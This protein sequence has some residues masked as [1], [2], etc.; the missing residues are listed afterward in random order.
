MRAGNSSSGSGA[1]TTTGGVV[2]LGDSLQTADVVSVGPLADT[3]VA[4]TVLDSDLLQVFSGTFSFCAA[5]STELAFTGTVVPETAGADVEEAAEFF[6]FFFLPA[7]EEGMSS[8]GGGFAEDGVAAGLL[9]AP[10]TVRREEISSMVGTE[11]NSCC[12]IPPPSSSSDREGGVAFS[13]S[14]TFFFL[15]EDDEFEEERS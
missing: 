14:P 5:V 15:R 2:A 4:V 8:L 6:C 12:V 10:L 7:L 13:F 1:G 9:L 11:R 3:L